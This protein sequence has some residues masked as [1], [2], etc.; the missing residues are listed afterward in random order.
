MLQKILKFSS[1]LLYGITFYC[2]STGWS[3]YYTSIMPIDEVEELK[4]RGKI[5]DVEYVEVITP[6]SSAFETEIALLKERC[7]FIG[8]SS[9]NGPYEKPQNAKDVAESVGANTVVANIVYTNTVNGSYTYM[10]QT[11]QTTNYNGNFNA[12][13]NGGYGFGNF[14]GNSTTYGSVPVTQ[15]YSIRRYDH[16]AGYFYCD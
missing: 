2:C 10:Q 12:S 16:F 11:Q 3:E 9:F 6:S 14:A 1:L 8:Y 15:Y 4:D 13:W 7:Y 5:K